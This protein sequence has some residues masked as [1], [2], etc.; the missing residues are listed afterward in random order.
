MAHWHL[1]VGNGPIFLHR[2]LHP[3]NHHRS[4]DPTSAKLVSFILVTVDGLRR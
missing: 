1:K 4:K 3:I 2:S